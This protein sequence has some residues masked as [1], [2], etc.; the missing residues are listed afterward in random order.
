MLT[1]QN[2]CLNVLLSE[3]THIYLLY[4]YRKI[5]WRT[6]TSL[7]NGLT[8]DVLKHRTF[9][10][11]TERPDE[12]TDSKKNSKW[13]T[14]YVSLYHHIDYMRLSC[15]SS[16]RSKFS[17]WRVITGRMGK[18]P[19][20]YE[21]GTRVWERKTLNLRKHLV[22]QLC[23]T[24]L[25]PHGL[26]PTRFLCPWDSPTARILEWVASP[27]SRGS[28]PPRDGTHVSCIGRQVLYHWATREAQV[29]EVSLKK[30]NW[31]DF[32]HLCYHRGA[33]VQ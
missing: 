10:T 12:I 26:R 6:L 29:S 4:N 30:K 16:P 7:A 32:Q 19:S 21:A 13:F 18:L 25:Q 27:I 11:K 17:H 3:T 20:H 24:L 8:T 9:N 5:S 23:V 31:Q 14:S 28:S 1:V 2:P 15:S 33:W 22:A